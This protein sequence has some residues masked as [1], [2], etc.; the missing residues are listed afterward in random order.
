MCT[1]PAGACRPRSARRSCS[2]TPRPFDLRKEDYSGPRTLEERSPTQVSSFAEA[3]LCS[4]FPTFPTAHA[5][6]R[7]RSSKLLRKPGGLAAKRRKTR[8]NDLMLVFCAFCAFL[9]QFPRVYG[10]EKTY[11]V[12]PFVVTSLRSRNA[13]PQPLAAVSSSASRSP[14]TRDPGQPPIPERTATYC[15]PSGPR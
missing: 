2:Q 15:L 8:K 12:P 5:Q 1:R 11:S 4:A 9:P 14:A 7:K 3:D 10:R 13:L 6:S